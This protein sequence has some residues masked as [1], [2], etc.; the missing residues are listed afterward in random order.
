ME[1]VSTVDKAAAGSAE[2]RNM[3]QVESVV[4][5]SRIYLLELEKKVHE[6]FK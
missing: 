4:F 1:L 3:N 6:D 2:T 5:L